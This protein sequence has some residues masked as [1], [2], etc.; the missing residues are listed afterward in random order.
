MMSTFGKTCL[1]GTAAAAMLVASGCSDSSDSAESLDTTEPVSSV[2]Q[3]TSFED[4]QSATV[5][6]CDHYGALLDAVDAEHGTLESLYDLVVFFCAFIGP[7]SE[8]T[9]A[10]LAV[11][12]PDSRA[13]EVEAF[14]EMLVSQ[15]EVA[16]DILSA[17][18]ADDVTEIEEL[19]DELQRLGESLDA[20]TPDLGVTECD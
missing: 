13:D 20:T 11:P 1:A 10:L 15:Q 12:V 3:S 14:H 5:E 7:A 9:A 4:W 19:S 6:V 18:R 8:Y 17:A 2:A 16:E